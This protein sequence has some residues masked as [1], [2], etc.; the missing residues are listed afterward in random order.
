MF[1]LG[2][3]VSVV[4]HLVFFPCFCFI[5]TVSTDYTNPRSPKVGIAPR[6][7]INSSFIYSLPHLIVFTDHQFVQDM[8]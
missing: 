6:N 5:D 7:T 8:K 3:F 4:F 1:S 2:I